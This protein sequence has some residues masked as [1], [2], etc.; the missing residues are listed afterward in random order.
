MLH[1]QPF[2]ILASIDMK[3]GKLKNIDDDV[4]TKRI[5]YRA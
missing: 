1:S 3:L 4:T 2:K 5:V